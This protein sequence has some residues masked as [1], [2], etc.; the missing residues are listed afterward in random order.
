VGGVDVVLWDLFVKKA[1]VI[2]FF[3]FLVLLISINNLLCAD[4]DINGILLLVLYSLLNFLE[5]H[6]VV[7]YVCGH[8][9]F[10]RF[11]VFHCFIIRVKGR[12]ELFPDLLIV[13]Q[14][15][16]YPSLLV[17]NVHKCNS[18]A[19]TCTQVPSKVDVVF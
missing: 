9:L 4:T 6:D 18:E 7:P 15:E 5:V 2:Q 3:L 1:L 17:E 19:N 10:L 8:F 14:K 11:L 16:L 13:S 12:R